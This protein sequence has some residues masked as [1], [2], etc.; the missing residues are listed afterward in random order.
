MKDRIQKFINKEGI[1]PAHFADE[2]GVQRSSVSHI[3]SGRNNPSFDFIQKILQ[4][5]KNLSAEWLLLGTGDIYKRIEK[6]ITFTTENKPKESPPIQKDLF[7]SPPLI[8]SDEPPVYGK[9]AAPEKTGTKS[10]EKIIV[11]YSDKTFTEFKPSS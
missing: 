8:Q 9:P 3:L 10:I 1:S 11:F 7:A 6:N 5:Y 4:R 2:I